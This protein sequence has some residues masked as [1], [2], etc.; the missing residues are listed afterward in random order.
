MTDCES[1][2]TGPVATALWRVTNTDYET[3]WVH[4]L[5][6]LQAGKSVQQ[7]LTADEISELPVELGLFTVQRLTPWHSDKPAEHN[8]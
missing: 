2:L 1:T 5:V 4:K 6:L 8:A 3:R 7:W